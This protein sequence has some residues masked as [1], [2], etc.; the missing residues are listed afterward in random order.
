LDLLREDKP[1]HLQLALMV[2]RISFPICFSL[3]E[4]GMAGAR[5]EYGNI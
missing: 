4:R 3:S 2:A 1:L 5:S